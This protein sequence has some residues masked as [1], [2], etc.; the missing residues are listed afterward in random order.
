[1]TG[2][3]KFRGVVGN[4]DTGPI[5]LGSL[6]PPGPKSLDVVIFMRL[7]WICPRAQEMYITNVS[8]F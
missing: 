1:M 7:I 2:E 6:V 5:S 4:Y 8:L 3:S